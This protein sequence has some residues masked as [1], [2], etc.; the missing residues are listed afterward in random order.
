MQ[1]PFDVQRNSLG[2]RFGQ[3]RTTNPAPG[4]VAQPCEECK[5]SSLGW[6]EPERNV[7]L[8]GA[9]FPKIEQHSAKE[10]LIWLGYAGAYE[11]RR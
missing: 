10:I 3:E 9:R 4:G 11:V 5:P 1:R 6:D 8:A 2:G 7:I